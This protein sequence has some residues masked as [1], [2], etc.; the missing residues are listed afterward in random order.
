MHCTCPGRLPARHAPSPF[1]AGSFTSREWGAHQ[2]LRVRMTPPELVEHLQRA[3]LLPDTLPCPCQLAAATTAVRAQLTDQVTDPSRTAFP[4]MRAVYLALAVSAR[5]DA[6]LADLIQRAPCTWID[7]E[8]LSLLALRRRPSAALLA[9]VAIQVHARPL[10]LDLLLRCGVPASVHV[11]A[12]DAFAGKVAHLTAEVSGSSADDAAQSAMLDEGPAAQLLELLGA[13]PNMPHDAVAAASTRQLVLGRRHHLPGWLW[14]HA[15]SYLTGDLWDLACRQ[16]RDAS[17]ASATASRHWT[18]AL[19]SVKGRTSPQVAAPLAAQLGPHAA[20][21]ASPYAAKA[22]PGSRKKAPAP[23]H[24]KIVHAPTPPSWEMLLHQKDDPLVQQ[25]VRSCEAGQ[26]RSARRALTLEVARTPQR[27]AQAH[28]SVAARHRLVAR[29]TAQLDVCHAANDAERTRLWE[30]AL[31]LCGSLAL[32][33]LASLETRGRRRLWAQAEQLSFARAL[34]RDAAPALVDPS[35]APAAWLGTQL[36]PACDDAQLLWRLLQR[37][38]PDAAPDAYQ[39]ALSLLDSFDGTVAQLVG[40][41]VATL[42][43]PGTVADRANAD[44]F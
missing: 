22:S 20:P 34:D 13:K 18:L 1:T 27:E 4:Q 40:L 10:L 33:P 29:L 9:A 38:L 44:T 8:V 25:L 32:V 3:A 5:S 6:E 16:H 11:A 36:D 35:R 24:W 2:R 31:P 7:A 15:T 26:T 21:V 39:L 12:L 19:R 43:P 37:Q 28:A 41:C 14:L 17:L 30:A 42:S 23:G